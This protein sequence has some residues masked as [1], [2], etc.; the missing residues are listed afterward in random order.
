MHKFI[1]NFVV[2]F[3]ELVFRETSSFSEL[4]VQ[5]E[6]LMV[7]HLEK[8]TMQFVLSVEKHVKFH[9]SLMEED[10]FTAES[11][12]LNEDHREEIDTKLTR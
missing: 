9:S 6:C 3:P 2:G 8:C 1:S 10:L 5:Y 11:V 4:E 7:D 12:M